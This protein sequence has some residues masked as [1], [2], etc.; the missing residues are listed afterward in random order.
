MK[1]YTNRLK[2]TS[3]A[4]LLYSEIRHGYRAAKKAMR[5]LAKKIINNEL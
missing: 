1:P 2:R 5:Q 3:Q 4:A